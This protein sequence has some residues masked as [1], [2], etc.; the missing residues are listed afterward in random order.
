MHKTND[1]AEKKAL[2]ELDT[3]FQTI[4]DEKRTAANTAERIGNAF[5]AILPYLGEYL[6]KDQDETAEYLLTLLKGAVIGESQNIR[7]NPDGSIRCGRIVVDGSAIFNE[8]VFNRQNVLEGDTFFSDRAIIETVDV[9]DAGVY[10]LTFRKEYD[11]DTVT[12][13]V[14]DIIRCSSNNLDTVGTYQTSY[15][16]VETVD[17]DSNSCLVTL[18]GDAE[19]PGG[20]NYAPQA[21]LRCI[22]WGNV[23]DKDRQQLFFV[24]STDG[25]FL[26]LQGVDAPIVDD[27]NYAAF[28]GIPPQM[29][30]LKDL[31]LNARQPYV[32]ARGLI[33]QDIIRID[34]QGNPEYTARDRG[35]WQADG[36]YIHGYD[37]TASGYYTDQVWYGGCLWRCAA[38]QATVGLP[39][40]F[41]NTEW[42]CLIG[43]QNMS[44]EIWSTAGDWFHAGT[45]WTTDLVCELYNAEMQLTAEDVGLAYIVWT[46]ESDD[47][48]GDTAWNIKHPAGS[49]GL[50]LHVDSTEDLP[51]TWTAGSRVGFVCAVTFPDGETYSVGYS[52]VM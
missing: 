31:P 8:L 28:L 1:M 35:L 13:H 19:V 29:E 9:V 43:G 47:T 34:Y 4:R 17:T 42:V 49:T 2:S 10:R 50:T 30:C 45:D 16:R 20:V 18:Y 12:F 48:A 21:S 15:V 22:R 11:N 7:L 33:V 24:S 44:M 37:S 26:F 36:V 5:L 38:A 25:T 27:S 46:R 51:S 23:V 41:N 32:Y 3:L 14:N 40:R 6:R 52:I 39:P